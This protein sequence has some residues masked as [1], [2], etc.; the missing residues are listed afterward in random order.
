[1]SCNSRGSW[2]YPLRQS[3]S[4]NAYLTRNAGSSPFPVVE[5]AFVASAS[6]AKNVAANASLFEKVRQTRAE[7]T[8]REDKV[9]GSDR[10]GR[11]LTARERIGLLKDEGTEVLEVAMFAGLSMPYGDIYNASGITAITTICGEQCMIMATD[12]TFKGGTLYPI[13]VKKQLRMQEI[14][15]MNRLP[16]VYLIDSGGAFLPLQVWGGHRA[17]H[18]FPSSPSLP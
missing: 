6:T 1:M 13:S 4:L 7:V 17:S 2:R 10:E 9:A 5:S 11:K 18:L 15:K 3:R 16:C 8:S 14:A 12:W